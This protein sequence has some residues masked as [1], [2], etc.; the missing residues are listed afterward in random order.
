MQGLARTTFVNKFHS[1]IFK[2]FETNTDEDLLPSIELVYSI[3][4]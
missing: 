2:L 3:I 1:P 4:L